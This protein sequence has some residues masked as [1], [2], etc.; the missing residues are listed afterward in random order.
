MNNIFEL[1]HNIL[2]F[3]KKYDIIIN[4]IL[5]FLL[6]LFIFSRINNLADPT[7]ELAYTL[8]GTQETVFL[9]LVSLIF[10][11]SPPSI[12]LFLMSIVVAFQLSANVAL[13][14][15]VFAI[16]SLIIIFYA[17]LAPK[18]SL[19]IVA[20]LLGFYLRMPY[21]V[22]LFGG[23]YF[24]LGAII[25]VVIGAAI[26]YFLPFLQEMSQTIVPLEE[27]D[28]FALPTT[29]L[30]TFNQIFTQISTDFNWVL[31]GFVFSMMVLAVY[32][33]S[34][35]GIN[36]SKEIAVG[37]GAAVGMVCMIMVVFV[38]DLELNILGIIIS[39]IFSAGIVLAIRFFDIVLDYNRVENVNFEDED[40]VYYVKIIP[41]K[42]ISK[43]QPTRRK[44]L[45]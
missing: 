18:Q 5:K 35:V 37:I 23:L 45:D 16:L 44:E 38:T 36:Y 42:Q 9:L 26:W 27:I 14:V 41:K 40:N 17:R 15:L 28:L 33:I 19:L 29:F 8:T 7:D 6:G 24:G 1:R 3:Y 25:A 10:T 4:Y 2:T 22:V 21:A 31:L 39:S 11:I 20:L 12:S 30:E 43:K 32:L 13:A 34:L